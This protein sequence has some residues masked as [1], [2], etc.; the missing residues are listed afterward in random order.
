MIEEGGWVECPGPL[1]QPQFFRADPYIGLPTR[2]CYFSPLFCPCRFFSPLNLPQ[3]PRKGSLVMAVSI[4]VR[5]TS[6]RRTRR[7]TGRLE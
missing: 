7:G 6:R 5:R 4:T 3:P 1:S 2:S